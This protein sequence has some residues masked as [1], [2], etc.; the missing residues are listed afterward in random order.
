LF[1]QV[2][3]FH[4]QPGPQNYD[5][6]IYDA[7]MLLDGDRM[8][9]ADTGGWTYTAANRDDATWIAAKKMSWRDASEWMGSNLRYGTTPC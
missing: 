5:S 2:V 6:I 9:W 1:E 8:Y 4:L 3:T 7:T